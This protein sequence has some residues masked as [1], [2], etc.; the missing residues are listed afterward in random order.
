MRDG[1]GAGPACNHSGGLRLATSG[2]EVVPA[3]GPSWA[4]CCN[5]RVFLSRA[6]VADMPDPA[7]RPQVAYLT[8]HN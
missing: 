2:R 8:G 6:P 5:A 1:A 3:L 7:G 4:A